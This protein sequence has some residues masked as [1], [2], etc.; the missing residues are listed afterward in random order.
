MPQE[1]GIIFLSLQPSQPEAPRDQRGPVGV[2]PSGTFYGLIQ[3]QAHRA[4]QVPHFC[5]TTRGSGQL[6]PGA[7]SLASPW[8]RGAAGVRKAEGWAGP[9]CSRAPGPLRPGQAARVWVAG[10]QAGS[11][12]MAVWPWAVSRIRAGGQPEG[13]PRERD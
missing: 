2:G 9:W 1:N 10:V 3:T 11:A 13:G 4:K 12:W 6:A 5:V 7:S 8:G